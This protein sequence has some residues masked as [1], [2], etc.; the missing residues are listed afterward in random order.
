MLRAPKIEFRLLAQWIARTVGVIAVAFLVVYGVYLHHVWN[1]APQ[2]QRE[3]TEVHRWTYDLGG[4]AKD[5]VLASSDTPL[6][7]PWAQYFLGLLVAL[8]ASGWGQPVFFL[9]QSYSVGFPM[10]FP[11]AYTLKE[12]L[13][14]HVIT[15]VAIIGSVL[16]WRPAVRSW[17]KGAMTRWLADNFTEFSFLVVLAVLWTA[18]MRSHMN[19]GVRHLLPAF[20]FMFILVAKQAVSLLEWL[21]RTHGKRAHS[22]ACVALGLLLGWQAFTVLRLHPSYLAY[23]NELAGGPD[24]GWMYLNDSNLDWGQ[25]V[26][27]LAQFVEQQDIEEIH[28]DY[29]GPPD[30]VYYFSEKYKGPVGCGTPPK[31]WVAVSAMLYPGAPWNAECDYRRTLP[32]EKLKAKIGYSIFVFHVE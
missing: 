9:G 32:I 3:L 19:I 21:A 10:Y 16:L 4:T 7:Q 27:R 12:P 11:V 2:L 6:L 20:P 8:K 15:A 28:V 17:G 23:F 31:G 25:D 14:L 1:Y 24:G 30:P 13:A 29:F 18:L 26:K 5:L 22:I